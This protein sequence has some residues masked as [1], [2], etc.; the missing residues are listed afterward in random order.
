MLTTSQRV[1]CDIPDV[2]TTI[3]EYLKYFGMK[4][5]L[6]TKYDEEYEKDDVVI[7]VVL[8]ILK[9][10][11]SDMHREVQLFLENAI[12]DNSVLKIRY[13]Q[14]RGEIGC[15][16]TN[17]IILLGDSDLYAAIRCLRNTTSTMREPITKVWVQEPIKEKFLWLV[18]EYLEEFLT[19]DSLSICT[20]RTM[21][22]L[23]TLSTPYEMNMVSIWTEDIIFAKNLAM[24][25]INRDVLFINTHMDFY[26][27]IVLLPYMI[28]VHDEKWRRLL[29]PSFNVSVKKKRSPKKAQQALVKRKGSVYNLF[30]DGILQQP[31]ED[32]YWIH[33][34]CEWAN[35]TSD[36]VDNCINSAEQGFK[37]W[38]S[39]SV[40]CRIQ[41]LSKFASTLVRNGEYNLADKILK[42]IKFSCIYENSLSCAQSGALEVTKLR[43]P[44]GIVI[45]KEANET[46][47]F[48]RLMQTLTVGNS[49]IVICDANSC[50]LIS[51]C[52]MFSVSEIP[53]GV[54]NL[55]SSLNIKALKVN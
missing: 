52:N 50:N 9:I 41:I 46:V 14:L 40:T 49:V 12:I 25:L 21:K 30:Y 4:F 47:L 54:I 29:S 34:N 39:K 44:N 32:T 22:E 36:D 13:E 5:T 7:L 42:W 37:I 18:E 24:S 55:L 10:C 6:G 43:N 45:L 19:V 15:D 28:K 3:I 38:S 35:A 20:F 51:Y 17:E 1:T 11:E 8:T 31:V 23:L 16:H 2:L 48:R 27:G 33:G 26:G 53:P